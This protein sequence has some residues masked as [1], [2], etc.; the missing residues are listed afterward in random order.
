MSNEKL[1]RQLRNISDSFRP[2]IERAL[3]STTRKILKDSVRGMRRIPNL[4]RYSQKTGKP[5]YIVPN[6]TNTLRV[7]TG[8]LKRS[9]LAASEGSNLSGGIFRAFY[10]GESY[11]ILFGSSVVDDEGDSYPREHDFGR[12]P[13]L[14]N[15]LD[16]RVYLDQV[17]KEVNKAW[18]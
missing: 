10:S 16:S 17:V 12:F 2:A 1:I 4:I 6:R 7:L 18:R 8:N 14:Q 5:Y 9:I 15:K 3:K 13:F 11:N